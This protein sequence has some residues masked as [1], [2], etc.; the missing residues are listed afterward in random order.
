ML[1]SFDKNKD[2]DINIHLLH[3]NSFTPNSYIKLINYLS[4]IGHVKTSVLR[5]LWKTDKSLIF[6]NWDIFL[7]DYLNDIKNE[8]KIIGI[9]HSIGGNILLKAAIKM[10]QNFEKIILLDPTFFTPNRIRLWKIISFFNL[11]SKFLPL[12]DYAENKRMSYDNID[13]MYNNYRR[14]KVFSKFSDEDLKI[15]VN[16]LI[17]KE[18]EKIKLL[19][20]NKFDAHIYRTSL[21]NDMFIWKNIKNLKIET[22]IIRAEASDVF[23]KST[24]KLVA[25]KNSCIKIVSLENSDHLFP[26]NNYKKTFEIINSFI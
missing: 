15:L 26:I 18:Q 13:E 19:F 4:I 24:S 10:P 14:Y 5:P 6:S 7:N 21:I 22:L 1:K 3:G 8:Q 17:Y 25:K 16:S 9:G 12:I 2:K 11:Q 20:D 23:L